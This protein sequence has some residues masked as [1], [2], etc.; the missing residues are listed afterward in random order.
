ME[1]EIGKNGCC[2]TCGSDVT[3]RM[4]LFREQKQ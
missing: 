2:S 1:S 4:R 3:D